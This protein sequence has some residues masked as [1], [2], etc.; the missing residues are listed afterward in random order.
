MSPYASSGSFV[1]RVYDGTGPTAWGAMTWT[2]TVPAG[3]SLALSVR[4]GNTPTPDGT[5][6][7]FTPVASSGSSVGGVAR[8]IQYSAQ[9]TSSA[10]LTPALKDVS[11]TC[12]PCTGPAPVAIAD[13]A[14]ARQ[15]TGGSTGRLPVTVTFTADAAA[16][17]TEVYRAPFGGYPR[18]DEAGGAVPA[19]PSYPPGAPW[20]LTAVTASGQSDLPPT[21]DQ[22]HYVAFSRNTCGTVSVCRIARPA[23]STTSWAT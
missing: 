2:S 4:K 5:W 16:T 7:A 9:L 22:W 18:Y 11:I 10:D 13:L 1:S 8:Y 15:S 14:A 20:T 17:A 6:T 12:T 19:T 3:T 21:R 23:C